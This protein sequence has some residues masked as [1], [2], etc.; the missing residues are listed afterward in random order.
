[1]TDITALA[2]R[3]DKIEQSSGLP[4]TGCWGVSALLAGLTAAQPLVVAFFAA[5]TD[6]DIIRIMFTQRSKVTLSAAESDAADE[7]T[8]AM[9]SAGF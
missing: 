5:Q 2:A 4:S 7:L 8:V 1:M 6:E 3:M 9:L